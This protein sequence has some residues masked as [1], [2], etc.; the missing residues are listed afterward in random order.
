MKISRKEIEYRK[1]LIVKLYAKKVGNISSLCREA[2]IS[3]KTYYEW[4]EN[5]E[6]FREKIFE[7]KE[8]LKDFL[9]SKFF[10]NVAAGKEQSI[11]FGLRT[12]AKD[13][14]WVEQQ[15]IHHSGSA[16]PITGI[17]VEIVH[18]ER[19]SLPT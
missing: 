19:N 6:A 18:R 5:D 17:T 16:V 13:R 11:L 3:R 10:E 4:L 12:I 14:G 15:H 9:E 8:S 2:E 1:S 7:A